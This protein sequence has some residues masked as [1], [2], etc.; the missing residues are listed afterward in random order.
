MPDRPLSSGLDQQQPLHARMPTLADDDVVV[1]GD[2]ERLRRLDD[3]PGHLDI[4]PRRCRVAGRV[5]V[6]Q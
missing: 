5:V 1:H 4:G 3:Q 6:D 2:A